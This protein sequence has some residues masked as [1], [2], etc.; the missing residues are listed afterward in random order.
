MYWIDVVYVKTIS[1]KVCFFLI[2]DAI[3]FDK[4]IVKAF[5][6]RSFLSI[7]ICDVEDSESSKVIKKVYFN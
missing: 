4:Y 1:T 6:S 2:M 5:C 3:L 7:R